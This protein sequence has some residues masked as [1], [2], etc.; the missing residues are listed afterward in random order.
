MGAPLTCQDTRPGICPQSRQQRGLQQQAKQGVSNHEGLGGR[1]ISTAQQAMPA[2]AK[3]ATQLKSEHRRWMILRKR[4]ACG[5]CAGVEVPPHLPDWHRRRRPGRRRRLRSGC[6]ALRLPPP[7]ARPADQF[8]LMS[9]SFVPTTVKPGCTAEEAATRSTSRGAEA[10][11]AGAA[12]CPTTCAACLGGL[13]SRKP[14][15]ASP[16]GRDLAACRCC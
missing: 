11:V 5:G 3:L 2:K 14:A 10:T 15:P 16:R 9:M 12:T 8:A 6:P 4:H 1:G 7:Q 13:I